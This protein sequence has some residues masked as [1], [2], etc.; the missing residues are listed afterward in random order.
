[1][2]KFGKQTKWVI[3]NCWQ[4]KKQK[5]EFGNKSKA[6]GA[7]YVPAVASEVELVDGDNSNCLR[8]PSISNYPVTVWVKIIWIADIQIPKRLVHVLRALW[9]WKENA[10]LVN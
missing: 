2:Q 8:Y 10:L 1:M 6:I 7:R 9:K 4:K 3:D 5:Q